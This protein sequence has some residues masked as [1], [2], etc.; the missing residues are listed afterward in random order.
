MPVP[1]LDKLSELLGRKKPPVVPSPDTPPVPH[2]P[3]AVDYVKAWRMLKDIP[4]QKLG[5]VV[6]LSAVIV[7]FAI[8]GVLAWIS[9]AVKFMFGVGR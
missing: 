1:L 2:Q 3:N 6:G 9:L 8:S 5:Q 4:F 7:F